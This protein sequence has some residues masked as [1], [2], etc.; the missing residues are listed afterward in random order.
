MSHNH[1]PIFLYCRTIKCDGVKIVF[2]C[3]EGCAS[4]F[5]LSSEESEGWIRP[6]WLR[7][8]EPD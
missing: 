6:I 3:V 5:E 2:F 8:R 1:V 7:L 4:S